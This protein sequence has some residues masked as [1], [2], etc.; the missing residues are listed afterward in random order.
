[1]V[2]LSRS[3]EVEGEWDGHHGAEAVLVGE[4]FVDKL[5][6]TGGGDAALG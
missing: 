3:D 5:G 6:M 2:R 4:R 1:L